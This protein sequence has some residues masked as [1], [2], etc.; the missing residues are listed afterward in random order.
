MKEVKFKSIREIAK[1]GL[2]SEHYLRNMVKRGD[3]PCIKSGNKFLI[4]EVALIEKLDAMSRGTDAD[5]DSNT[6]TT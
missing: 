2:I 4:N 6:T 3:C 1:T 5:E